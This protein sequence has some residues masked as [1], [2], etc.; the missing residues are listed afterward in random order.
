M[1]LLLSRDG[2]NTNFLLLGVWFAS[3]LHKPE[4]ELLGSFTLGKHWNSLPGKW[5]NHQ[6]RKCSKNVWMR[7]SGFSGGSGRARLMVGLDNC[8][9]FSSPNDSLWVIFDGLP[10]A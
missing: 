2:S 9:G 7:H 8:R 4:T 5:W 10:C 1:D 3:L 6:P